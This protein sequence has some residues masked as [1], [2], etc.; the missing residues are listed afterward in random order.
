MSLFDSHLRHMHFVRQFLEGKV[1]V[2]DIFV[3]F[4]GPGLLSLH[5]CGLPGC[6]HPLLCSHSKAQ[7]HFMIQ[8]CISLCYP[9]LLCTEVHFTALHFATRNCDALQCNAMY[10]KNKV[11]ILHCLPPPNW[12]K[13]AKSQDTKYFFWRRAL[14]GFYLVEYLKR[15]SDIESNKNWLTVS[16][17]IYL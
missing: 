12:S 1:K 5:S 14:T 13:E 15:C 17:S 10:C 2:S 3:F 7:M 8:H 6:I 9:A 16:N 11:C 4:L